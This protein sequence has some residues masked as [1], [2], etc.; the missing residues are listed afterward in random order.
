MSLA[1]WIAL[2]PKG[3]ISGPVGIRNQ[4]VDSS[5]RTPAR[6]GAP[7]PAC[8]TI[9]YPI[10]AARFGNG[11]ARP[12]LHA[13]HASSSAT[14]QERGR[15]SD[16]KQREDHQ[17]QIAAAHAFSL[18]LRPSGKSPLARKWFKEERGKGIPSPPVAA[19]QDE[20]SDPERRRTGN[21]GRNRDGRLNLSMAERNVP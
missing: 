4:V 13:A 5:I 3:G 9:P 19:V 18:C 11:L 1:S 7:I 6:R 12:C 16:R 20:S 2:P 15:A 17:N 14:R 8:A 10:L 21:D